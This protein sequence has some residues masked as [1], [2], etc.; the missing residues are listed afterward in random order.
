MSRRLVAVIAFAWIVS[1]VSVAVWAQAGDRRPIQRFAGDPV[2]DVITAENIGFQRVL[3]DPTKDGKVTGRWMVR[4][5]GKW[6]ET[7]TPV[8]V[9]R[10]G[11]N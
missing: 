8:G 2:G 3:A 1:L 6:M 4:I 5:N 9:V 11:S 7:Q 10:G